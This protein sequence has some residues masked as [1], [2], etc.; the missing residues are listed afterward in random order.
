MF[1]Y[2]V[3]DLQTG[4]AVVDNKITGTLNYIDSGSLADYWGAGY[5]LAL[6][7]TNIDTHA[8]SVKVGL[9]PSQGSGLVEIINDPEKNGAF[10]ITNKDTQ[11]FKVVQIDG[12]FKLVQTYDLSELILASQG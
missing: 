9:S 10:K 4:A 3:S 6:K 5:F 8:T 1:G 2:H 12:P 11:V 7:F